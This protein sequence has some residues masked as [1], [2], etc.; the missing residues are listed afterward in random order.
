MT[1]LKLLVLSAL[2][3]TMMAFA[4]YRG[5]K[6]YENAQETD[7]LLLANVEALAQDGESNSGE[8]SCYIN[9]TKFSSNTEFKT[10]VN[11]NGISVSW[12]RTCQS[13]IT[14][15]KHTGK[16]DDICYKSLNGVVTTCG[17]WSEN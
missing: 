4:F 2:G 5:Y 6:D 8:F 14:Y 13:A 9:D 7:H 16:E 11:E 10:E 12:K 17:E 1:N 3:F 15:C